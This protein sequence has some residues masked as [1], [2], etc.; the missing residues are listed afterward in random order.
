MIRGA[1]LDMISAFSSVRFRPGPALTSNSGMSPSA[2]L[3][4]SKEQAVAP[5][6]V[7]L[8]HFLAQA[9]NRE[10]PEHLLAELHPD[11]LRWLA[12]HPLVRRLPIRRRNG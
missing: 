7:D 11:D 5:P 12:L 3:S 8:L 2:S 10:L 4:H 6:G 9:M 1:S